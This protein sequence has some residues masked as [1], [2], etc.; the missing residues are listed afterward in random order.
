MTIL[1]GDTVTCPACGQQVTATVQSHNNLTALEG[2]GP[3]I[4]G[5]RYHVWPEASGKDEER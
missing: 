1:I 4:D 3:C 5:S 2:N